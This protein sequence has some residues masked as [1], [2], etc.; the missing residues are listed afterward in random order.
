M[1][2]TSPVVG[3][4]EFSGEHG[5]KVRVLEVLR[6]VIAHE[7][8]H[9]RFVRALPVPLDG[10]ETLIL[11]FKKRGK[12]EEAWPSYLPPEPLG[13]ERGNRKD[14][15]VDE[16]ADLGVVV[17]LG[18]RATVQRVPSGQ[19]LLGAQNAGD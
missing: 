8:D 14:A 5:P 4:V 6:V 11:I 19:V 10:A 1:K 7:L 9:V 12:R 17:P 16:N 15:P 3:I 18:Q 2:E 13:S